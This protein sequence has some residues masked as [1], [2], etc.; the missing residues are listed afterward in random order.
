[1]FALFRDP[2]VYSR[3]TKKRAASFRHGTLGLLPVRNRFSRACLPW[4]DAGTHV[5][6]TVCV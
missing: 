3:K 6:M 5:I 4:P 1:V 2:R